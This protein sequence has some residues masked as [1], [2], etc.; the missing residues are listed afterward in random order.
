M[1]YLQMVKLKSGIEQN[2][3]STNNCYIYNIAF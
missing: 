1:Q 3:H 2:Y